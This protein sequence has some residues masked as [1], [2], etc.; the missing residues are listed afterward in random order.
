MTYVNNRLIRIVSAP[1]S[2]M[3]RNLHMAEAR[4]FLVTCMRSDGYKLRADLAQPQQQS[5]AFFP[6]QLLTTSLAAILAKL[7]FKHKQCRLLFNYTVT[8]TGSCQ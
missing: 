2:L 3:N 1:R 5:I 4:D 7:H 6:R 8:L